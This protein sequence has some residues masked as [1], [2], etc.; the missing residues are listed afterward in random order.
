MMMLV[1]KYSQTVG[2]VW[3]ELASVQG[4]IWASAF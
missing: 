2:G 3:P 1:S 4:R